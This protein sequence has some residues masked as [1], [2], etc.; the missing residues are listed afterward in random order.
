MRG[1]ENVLNTIARGLFALAGALLTF[2]MLLVIVDVVGRQLFVYTDG[3]IDWTIPGRLELV[4]ISLLFTIVG[5]LPYLVERGQVVVD[6]FTGG[7]SDQTKRRMFSVYLCGFAVFGAILAYGWTHTGLGTWDAGQT[8][9]DLRIPVAPLHF[10]AAACAAVLSAR[11]L[12]CAFTHRRSG[13][14][15]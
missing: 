3:A 14:A 1:I 12:L 9:Q 5:A 2:M 10:A 7:L 6:S 13:D 4:R 8:T 15:I 11:S